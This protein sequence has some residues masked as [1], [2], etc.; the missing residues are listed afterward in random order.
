L[1]WFLVVV[2]LPEMRGRSA[3]SQVL[4]LETSAFPVVIAQRVAG[5][6]GFCH[7]SSDVEPDVHDVDVSHRCAVV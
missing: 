3:S 1:R 6:R 2:A 5:G 7:W 4:E